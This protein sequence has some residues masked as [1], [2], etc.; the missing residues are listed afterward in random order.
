V[1]LPLRVLLSESG[2]ATLYIALR[3][4]AKHGDEIRPPPESERS[5]EINTEEE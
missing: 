4:A 3:E 1:K 2:S 5:R